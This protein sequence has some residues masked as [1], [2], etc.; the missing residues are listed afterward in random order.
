MLNYFFNFADILKTRKC[1]LFLL[2][3]RRKFANAP[4]ISS[5]SRRIRFELRCGVVAYLCA[6]FPTTGLDK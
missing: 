1:S 4:R 5:P 3:E 2:N 6:R